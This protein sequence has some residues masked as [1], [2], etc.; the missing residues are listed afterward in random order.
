MLP[1]G[2]GSRFAREL[3]FHNRVLGALVVSGYAPDEEDR[4]AM[5]RGELPLLQKPFTGN[6]LKRAVFELLHRD[7]Q[8][9]EAS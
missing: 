4:E 5:A 2:N 3:I 6:A 1:D 8:D 7:E 9:A